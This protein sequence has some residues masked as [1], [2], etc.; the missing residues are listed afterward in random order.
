M[1]ANQN[2]I[3]A[4]NYCV[5]FIDLLGQREAMHGQGLLPIF[6]TSDERIAFKDVIKRTIKPIYDLQEQA[7][8]LMDAVMNKRLESPL[9]ANLPL[10]LQ[11]EWDEMQRTAIKSQ[12]WSDGLVQFVCLGDT[13]IKCPMNG[14]FGLFGTAGISCLI[15]LSYHTP[16]RGAIDIAWGVELRGGELYGP[17]IAR[18]YELESECAQYPRIIVSSRTIDYLRATINTTEDDRF[19]QFNR[20]LANI[21]LAMLTEDADGYAILHYLGEEFQKTILRETQVGLYQDALAFIEEQGEKHR[22]SNN[23]KLALRYNHLLG[24][25]HAHKPV[26]LAT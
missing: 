20:A 6:H 24:Y 16:L 26:S 10:G 7:A 22:A 21:C 13:S 1:S 2:E 4:Y 15:G 5:C 18:A 9:R 25:F 8:H 11:S 3:A 17:V 12:H 19:S 14:I 23:T